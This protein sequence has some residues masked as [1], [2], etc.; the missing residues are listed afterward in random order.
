MCTSGVHSELNLDSR[1]HTT[2]MVALESPDSRLSSLQHL[3]SATAAARQE[4]EAAVPDL[5]GT[6]STREEP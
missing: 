4:V 1:P 5:S 3:G 6:I 2:A